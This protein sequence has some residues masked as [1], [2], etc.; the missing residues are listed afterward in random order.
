MSD[1]FVHLHVHSEYSLLDGLCNTGRLV[2]RAQELGQPAIAL[3]DHG[4]MFGTIEFYNAA[5]KAGLQPIIGIE[6]YL[7]PRSRFDRDP[8]KD[9]SQYHL[10][11]LAQNNTGVRNLYQLASLA[12]LEGFYYKPRVDKDILARYS[13]GLICLSGCGSSEV[14]ELLLN[15]QVDKAKSALTWYRETFG[16]ERYYLELQWHDNIPGLDKANAQLIRWAK[17]FDLKLVATNDVH[18]IHADDWMAQDVLL[19][20]GTGSLVSQPDRMRMTD[21]SYY[22]KSAE[23][24]AA[25]FGSEA[26]EALVTPLAIAEMCNVAL[27]PTGY[28]LPIFPVP[29]GH[30]AE[31]FLRQLCEDGLRE[32]YGARADDPAIRQRLDYEL[33][34][35]HQMGFDNYFLIV[36]DLTRHA[37]ERGIWWNV[38]GSGAGSM[39]AYCTGI[40][41]LDPLAHGLLFER[42]LN[43][44]RISMPDIDMDFPDDR[45]GEMIEYAVQKYGHENVAQIIAFGTMGAR[46]AVRDVGRALDIP[47]G[48]V[49]SVAKLIPAIPGKPVSLAEAI[50]QVPDLKQKYGSVGY[51]HELLDTAQKL[52]GVVRHASTHAAGVIISDRPLVEYTPLHRPT[53]GTD[54]SGL[55]IVTQFEMNTCD[56]IGLLKVDFLGLSTLTIMRRACELI[57]QNHGVEF[58]LENIPIDDPKA[59][60]LLARGD[61]AG[62]FQVEGSGMRRVLM[63]MRP[64]RF[65]HIV[66]AISLFRPGP[67]EYIPTYIRR[68]HGQE[69][70]EYKHPKLEPILAE[71]YGITVYQ[72]QIIRIA[73]E[74]AGYSPGDADQIR[75]AVGKKIREKIDEH[76][77]RFIHGAIQNGIEERVAASIYDDIEFFARYGFNK[78]HAADYA[79]ITCQTA[80]LK[81]HY[82]IEYMTALLSV[83]RNNT[84]KIG[85]LMAECRRMGIPVLKPSVNHSVLDFS[86]ETCQGKSGD[87][88]PAIRFGMGAIKNVGEG[89]VQ[90]ILEARGG[91]GPFRNLDDFCRRV[92]LRQVNRRALES[93]V[94][95]GAFDE[96]G[97]RAQLLTILDRMLGLSSQAHRAADLGQMTLF[98][99]A[100]PTAEM[101]VLT[102]LPNVEEA[103]AKEKLTWEKELVG[104]YI[105]EHPLARVM[106]DLHDTVTVMCGQISEDM[107]NQK[108]VVAGMVTY[109]RRLTT[110]KG[111]P[112]AFAGLEDLQGTTEIVLFPR[113]WQQTQSIWQPDKV[114][115]VRGKVDATGKQPKIIADSATDQISV[116]RPADAVPAPRPVMLVP[117]R[118][119][120]EPEPVWDIEPDIPPP[121]YEWTVASEAS[122]TSD[123]R[124]AAGPRRGL[125]NGQPAE[126]VAPTSDQ[127]TQQSTAQTVN[128]TR[129]R[130]LT[131]TLVR[132]GNH[133]R[134]M[135]L[136]SE[137][138]R[139][140][141]SR[142][143]RDRFKFRLTGGGNGAIEMEFPN[144]CTCFSPELVSDLEKMLG[145]GAVK[146]EMQP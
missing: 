39:G 97:R 64:T 114:V 21:R 135:S 31:S 52:E 110:K 51:I 86:I 124:S 137:A 129:P 48:E 30:T 3:T 45:R 69:K 28:H 70:V 140:L 26:P 111:D 60:E 99:A 134:D 55:G 94:K 18:Y 2:A 138:H 29:Q 136:L 109:V 1:P 32:R 33:T 93:L 102:P 79:V 4:V 133:E 27:D 24:M 115:L 132:S 126:P 35:I 66:A 20:V 15:G 116:A 91:D 6:A 87:C 19:C 43:P 107:A 113:V 123:E 49:D 103:P 88:I 121:D 17:E 95:A 10:L 106:A 108:V 50:E 120:A 105:S 101:S 100:G 131:I 41:R 23:E 80:F 56:A 118:H 77:A 72:E 146:V 63:E 130:L 54:E 68:M 11:L 22:L 122:V 84:D 8:Q 57:Q 139:L 85:F 71:T 112:M 62:V 96:F 9:K 40:T 76:R 74:L 67:L 119:V 104:G 44:G 141:T 145:P 13:E 81:A 46:A 25:L 37:K 78:A 5:K 82:P 53:K 34:V 98:G 75:K 73:S 92:D 7:A 127:P 144:H 12:Q 142:G 47:L 117:P 42:F 90:V 65:E 16:P 61:V 83:E 14:P 36:W 38:R 128:D 59:F 89:P 143:G 125:V 58:N